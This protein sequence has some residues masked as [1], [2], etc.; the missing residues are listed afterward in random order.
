MLTS[1]QQ[2]KLVSRLRH[3]QLGSPP[4]ALPELRG[5]PT[6]P[7][8]PTLCW[9]LVSPVW[10]MPLW[11][12]KTSLPSESCCVFVCLVDG[13]TVFLSSKLSV[14]LLKGKCQERG[15]K[16]GGNKGVLI[17]RLEEHDGTVSDAMWSSPPLSSRC[18]SMLT[19]H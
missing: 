13:L 14:T 1:Q 18:G 16:V 8:G 15:L 11:Q 4:L 3:Q 19:W 10:Q 9:W 2:A 7:T 17:A 5:D 12:M 6:C